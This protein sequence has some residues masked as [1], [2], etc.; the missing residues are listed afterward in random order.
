MTPCDK[1][2]DILPIRY[3]KQL[4]CLFSFSSLLICQELI[5]K[6]VVICQE[7]IK[8]RVVICQELIKKRVVICQELI[9]KR[10]VHTKLVIYVVY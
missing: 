4:S 2:L 5:K 1:L 7:L 9:K 10:V 3:C 6:H 8:K